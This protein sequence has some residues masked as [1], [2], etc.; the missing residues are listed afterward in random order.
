MAFS[1]FLH[2]VHDDALGRDQP[3]PPTP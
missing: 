1:H 2:D 3:I